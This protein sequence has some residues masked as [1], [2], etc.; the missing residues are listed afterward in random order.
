VA[1]PSIWVNGSGRDVSPLPL[2]LPGLVEQN[3]AD[4]R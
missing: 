1:V 2:I 3:F 4:R